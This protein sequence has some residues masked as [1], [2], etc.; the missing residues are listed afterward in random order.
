MV[1]MVGVAVH[2][3]VSSRRQE[4]DIVPLEEANE[5][6]EPGPV[7]DLLHVLGGVCMYFTAGLLSPEVNHVPFSPLASEMS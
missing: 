2:H 1:A 4:K 5:R 6:S 7:F 3:E